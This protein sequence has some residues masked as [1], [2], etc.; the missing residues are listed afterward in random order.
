MSHQQLQKP[1][2]ENKPQNVNKFVQQDFIEL[3]TQ[4]QEEGVKNNQYLKKPYIFTGSWLEG[5]RNLEDLYIR[6][7][8]I[9]NATDAALRVFNVLHPY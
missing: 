1:P 3:M 4:I 6:I 8:Q 5:L 7:K 2:E 9:P